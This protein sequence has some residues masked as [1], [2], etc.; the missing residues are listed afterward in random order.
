MSRTI[1]LSRCLSSA[2]GQGTPY[3]IIQLARSLTSCPRIASTL[4][5][6]PMVILTLLP[7]AVKG[8]PPGL[9]LET[10]DIQK[11]RSKILAQLAR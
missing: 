10:V 6:L 8:G 1:Y 3:S 5:P 7:S 2:A 4:E 9:A 11:V